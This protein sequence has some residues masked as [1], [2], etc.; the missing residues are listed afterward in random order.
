M[1]R[2]TIRDVLWLM[3]VLLPLRVVAQDAKAKAEAFK[4]RMA[5]KLGTVVTIR[6]R[7]EVY[8]VGTAVETYDGGAVVLRI[9]KDANRDP[10]EELGDWPVGTRVE[11]TGTIGFS[12][13]WRAPTPLVSDVAEHHFINI[14]TIR[15]LPRER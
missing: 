7:L 5:Q 8:K 3:V 6:G 9:A 4:E 2:F 11:V 10:F 1:I 15:R 12:P 13:Y 14:E